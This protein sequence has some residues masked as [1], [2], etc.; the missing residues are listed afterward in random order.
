MSKNRKRLEK[1][2]KFIFPGTFK[3]IIEDLLLI[4]T[5]AIPATRQFNFLTIVSG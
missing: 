5:V 3:I 1:T 4:R 2:R